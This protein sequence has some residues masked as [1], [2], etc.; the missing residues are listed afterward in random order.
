M[1]T[2]TE[3]TNFQKQSSFLA[4]PVLTRNSWTYGV[5]VFWYRINTQI[6]KGKARNFRVGVEGGPYL[7]L[8]LIFSKLKVEICTFSCICIPPEDST[9]S[10]YSRLVV[11]L[12]ISWAVRT[13]QFFLTVIFQVD[14]WSHKRL[15]ENCGDRWKDILQAECS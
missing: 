10:M 15:Q 1:S 3:V 14:R 5:I 7:E 2:Y 4:H 11:T 9:Y 6:N 12:E 13:L 8:E